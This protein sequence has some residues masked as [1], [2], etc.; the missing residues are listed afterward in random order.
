MIGVGIVLLLAAAGGI[1]W[2]VNKKDPPP[3]P[4][5]V[6]PAAS[7]SSSAPVANMDLPAID[8]PKDAEPE[9]SAPDTA[10]KPVATGGGGGGCGCTSNGQIS[11]A[12]KAAA[13]GKGGTAKTCYKTALEGNEGLA[14][15]IELQVKI[16]ANGETCGVTVLSD[17]VGS[18]KLQ[19]CVKGRM[20]GSYPA[21]KGGCVDVKVPVVFKPKT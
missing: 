2:Y 6:Q 16:G 8:L 13:A 17:S 15:T 4:P 3:P 9:D 5:K 18:M 11:D 20:Y 19:Q 12:I 1:L 7:V 10:T 14:G 21:P